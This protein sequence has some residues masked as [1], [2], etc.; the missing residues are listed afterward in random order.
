MDEDDDIMTDSDLDA[1]KD[2]AE[3]SKEMTEEEERDTI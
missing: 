3:W 2:V 1:A